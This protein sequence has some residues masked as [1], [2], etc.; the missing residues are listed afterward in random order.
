[1]RDY[2]ENPLGWRDAGRSALRRVPGLHKRCLDRYA[3]AEPAQ[4]DG[5]DGEES[6][7]AASAA[8]PQ[9]ATRKS[10]VDRLCEGRHPVEVGLRPEKTVKLFKE[11]IDRDYVQIKFTETKGGTELSVKLRREGCDFSQ[12]DFENGTGS[13]HVEGDLTLDYVKVRCVADVDLATLKGEGHLIKVS[14]DSAA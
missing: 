2:K 3:P 6:V 7:A 8:R 13:V 10:L 14:A 12:A 9:P 11:A 5:G 4:E 1:M